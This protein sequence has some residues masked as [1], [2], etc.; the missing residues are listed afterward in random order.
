[1]DIKR[2]RYLREILV[3]DRQGNTTAVIEFSYDDRFVRRQRFFG[4]PDLEEAQARQLY[5]EWGGSR[6]EGYRIGSTVG[7]PEWRAGI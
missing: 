6:P 5:I 7:R 3:S 4:V 1:M 2:V